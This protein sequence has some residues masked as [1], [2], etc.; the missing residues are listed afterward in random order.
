MILHCMDKCI[1]EERKDK[2]TWGK[3]NIEADGFIHCSEPEFF[4]RLV[5]YFEGMKK[6]LVILCIDEKKLVSEVRYE[7]GDDS[8]ICYPHVYGMINNDAVITV[9]PFL[10]DE[11]GTYIKNNELLS[12]DDR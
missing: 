8:G 12:I 4:W 2:V 6:K 1:W 9:L 11:K 5:P 7:T 10:T 3:R